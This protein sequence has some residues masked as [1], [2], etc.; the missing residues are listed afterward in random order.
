LGADILA[1]E[2]RAL[3]GEFRISVAVETLEGARALAEL[4]TSAAA[5]RILVRAA[6]A[7]HHRERVNLR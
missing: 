2:A 6:H 4:D 1:A 3:A 7:F 5:F